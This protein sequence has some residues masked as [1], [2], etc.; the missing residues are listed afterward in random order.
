MKKELID[1]LIF[2]RELKDNDFWDEPIRIVNDYL[3]DNEHINENLVS[4][5]DKGSVC[6]HNGKFKYV[7]EINR[8][9]CYECDQI[10]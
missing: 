2:F 6:E 4:D 3:R 7:N 10:F 9:Y 5:G 8:Y 1:F